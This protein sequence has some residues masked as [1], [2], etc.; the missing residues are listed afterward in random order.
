MVPPEYANY[1]VASTGASA[2]LLGLLFVSVSIAPERI[3][4]DD[5]NVAHRALALSSFTAL[6]NAF[7]ISLSGLIPDVPFGVFVIVAG[8]IALSQ[9]LWLLRSASAWRAERRLLRGIT[10]FI[11]GISIYGGETF[12][13]FGI[14]SSHTDRGL[15]S[16][17]LQ[18][19]L[20]VFAMGLVRAW[21]LLGAPHARGIASGAMDWVE[22]KVEK[23][24]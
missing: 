12:I 8:V 10:L 3:F 14:Y 15:I 16:G 1:F 2:A 5:T 17:L 13:G 7:F 21:E 6:A 20:A 23:K 4:G 18:L 19:L 24:P 9:S 11:A 22:G